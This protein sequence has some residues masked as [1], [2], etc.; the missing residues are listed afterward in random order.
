MGTAG[1]RH[2][3][4]R[5]PR[6][7]RMTQDMKVLV[8]GHDGYIGRVLMPIFQHAGHDVVGLD[9]FLFE[10]CSL[11]DEPPDVPAVRVDL[12]DLDPSY[13]EGFDAVVH[14]AAIS[15][16]PLGDL[17]P[18]ITYEVN[19]EASVALARAAKDAGVPRF[20]FSSS[21]S[22]YGASGGDEML[23]EH[24]DFHPI[25]PYGESKV[26]VERDVATLA[27]DAF[28]PT[29]L[30][31]A[32]A[33]G[34]SPRL[35]ADIVVN[36]LVGHAFT[37]GEVL[38]KSDGS[39][40]RPLV[41]VEDIARAFLAILEAPR[42]DVHNEA[43]NVG[44]NAENYRIREVAEMVA[45]AMPGSRVTFAEGAEPDLRTYRVDFSKL[46][47]SVPFRPRWTVRGGIEQLARA[48][49]EHGLTAEEFLGPRF[50]R[51]ERINQRL[52][53]GTLDGN[54]RP[55]STVGATA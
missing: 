10:G 29:F 36:N 17:D 26:L 55:T 39:P 30:R 19:H 25:T 45:D 42:D 3:D 46:A 44:R 9:S 1:D 49:R 54:L 34:V 13:L 35:R 38:I 5:D 20:L 15:N 47:E 48:Y 52:R 31:N 16:D 7:E 18:A 24:A 33:F 21:C 43:F 28:S 50:T 37:S 11:G 41:H 32:T 22:L 51:L 12:R 40:W 14:L 8:T 53:E 23:T 6:R 27:D 2:I 4:L